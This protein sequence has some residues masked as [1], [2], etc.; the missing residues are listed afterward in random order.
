M[1]NILKTLTPIFVILVI[2]CSCGNKHSLNYDYNTD[3]RAPQKYPDVRFAV[4]SDIHVY[5]Q[6]L[7][8]TGSAFEKVMLSDRKLLLDSIDL[9]DFGINEI[10][11]SDVNFVLIPGDLTKDGELINHRIVAEKLNILKEAGI[12]AYVVPGNHDV[13]NTEAFSFKGD[14]KTIVPTIS[15]QEFAQNYADFGFKDAIMRDSESL[16]YLTELCPGLLLLALDATRHREN[17]QGHHPIVGGKINQQTADWIALALREADK[18]NAAVIAMMHHGFMEHWKGQKKLHPDYIILDFEN[19]SKFLASWNV[20]VGF[21]GHYHAHDVTRSDF[22][23]KYMYDIE[24]GSLITAPCPIRYVQI[25]NNTLTIRSDFIVDK[26]HPG[27]DFAAKAKSFVKQTVMLEASST[28]RKFRVSENDIAIIADAVGD[29]FNAHYSGDENPGL[30]KT[31]DKSKLGLWGKFV[32]SVQQYV[33]DGLW[34]DLTPSDINL[35]ISLD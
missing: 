3:K 11:A 19:F 35:S 21:T 22:N 13:N 20:R 14:T 8:S 18:R 16:S 32:L 1:K 30:R 4:I 5:I 2:F 28:L 15:E 9:L 24:T 25:K 10:I 31:L 27:T 26:L 6:E 17:T 33:L 12:K 29:A 23:G 7:G 34:K